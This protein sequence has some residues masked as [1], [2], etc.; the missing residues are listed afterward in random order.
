MA[1]SKSARHAMRIIIRCFCAGWL[2]T[3]T[4]A[5]ST[6]VGALS[7]ALQFALHSAM[8]ASE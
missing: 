5:T 8:A 2:Q 7:N 6:D 3:L 1:N 4:L